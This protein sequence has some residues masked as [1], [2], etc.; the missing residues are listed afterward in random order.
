MCYVCDLQAFH[1]SHQFITLANMDGKT[2]TE[3]AT[4]QQAAAQPEGRSAYK[5]LERIGTGAY[6]T[7]Y[8]AQDTRNNGRLVAIKQIRIPMS[9]QGMPMNII[10]EIALL[11]QLDRFEHRNIVQ[12]FDVCHDRFYENEMRVSIVFEYIEQDLERYLKQHAESGLGHDR[13]RDL[14]HQLLTGVDFL[15]SHRIVHRDLKPQNILIT[16]QNQLKIADLGLA[17]VYHFTMLLTNVVVTLWYR[18][19]EVLL[20]Q[21]YATSVDLW[22]CGCIFAELYRRKPLFEGT[23]EPNQLFKIFE[24]IGLPPAEDWPQN[25]GIPHEAFCSQQHHFKVVPLETL[26]PD[27]CPDGKDLLEKLLTYNHTTRISALKALRHKYF[28]DDSS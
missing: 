9:E 25:V 17:R 5:L 11:K 26:V 7:V 24:V 21:S 12:C 15:H 13:I 19:P 16:A 3:T 1:A 10:R 14:M 6:G 23:S 18:A 27:I 28:S 4:T 2:Y 20:Q 22:S 8:K